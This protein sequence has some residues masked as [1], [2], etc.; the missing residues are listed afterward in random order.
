MSKFNKLVELAKENVEICIL[1]EFEFGGLVFLPT[2]GEDLIM[3]L[4]GDWYFSMLLRAGYRKS[5]I[6]RKINNM[7]FDK[8]ASA[9]DDW[10]KTEIYPKLYNKF[11][12]E[13]RKILD[14][15]GR[16]I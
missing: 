2:N 8:L 16:E 10:Y 11:K 9:L 3:H 14:V 13:G 7:D 1:Q 12:S 15:E 6:D 5:T 4:G